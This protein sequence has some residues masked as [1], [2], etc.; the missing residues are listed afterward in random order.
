MGSR[1][2]RYFIPAVIGFAPLL[3]LLLT[4]APDGPTSAQAIIKGIY[5]PVIG[6]EIFVIVIAFAQALFGAARRWSW[7]WLATGAIVVLLT[8]AIATAIFAPSPAAA[9][10]WTVI[11]VIHLLFGFSVAHLCG[12]AFR[13]GDLVRT[14]LLG[15]TLF[16]I[17]LVLFAMSVSDPGFDWVRGWPAAGHIRHLGYYIAAMIALCAGIAATERRRGVLVALFLLALCSFAFALWSGS[18]GVIVGVVGGLIAALVLLPRMRRPVVW[19]GTGV[20]L[21]LGGGVAAL[22]PAPDNPILGFARTVT[23]TVDSGNVTTGRTEIWRGVID[24]IRERP[25]FGYGD[26]QMSTVAH[27]YDMQTPHD[28]VLQIW[29]AWG[30]V[31]LACVAVLAVWFLLR[32]LPAIRADSALVPP[33]VAMLVLAAFSTIDNSLANPMSVSIFAAC[34]GMV[35]SGWRGEARAG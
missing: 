34:A 23:Q 20:A 16:L 22:I 19:I 14:Y 33:F 28:V 10:T 12:A 5:A 27:F 32:S 30:V 24:A 31:G 21:L 25:L 4:W 6:A 18:R 13:A 1:V 9:R 8:I 7:P 35:A 15:F 3:L 26:A 29:L 11:W 17:G 2:E